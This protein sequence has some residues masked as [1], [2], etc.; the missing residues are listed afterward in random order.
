MGVYQLV[1]P[2]DVV[3]FGFYFLRCGIFLYIN[4]AW[5]DYFCKEDSIFI[6]ILFRHYTLNQ[7]SIRSL[8]EVLSKQDHII[9]HRPEISTN[10]F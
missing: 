8:R 1:H 2:I 3:D 6:D 5:V 10:S 7:V 9:L 4:F